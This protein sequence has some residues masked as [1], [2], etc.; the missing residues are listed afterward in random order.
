MS[1]HLRFDWVDAGPSPDVLAQYTMAALSVDAGGAVITGALDR[2]SGTYSRNVVVPLFSIAEW[3]VANWWHIWHEVGDVDKQPHPAFEARHNLAFAGDGFVLPSLRMTRATGRMR[4]EWARYSPE[5]A[6]IEFVDAGEHEVEPEELETQ[7]RNLIDAV[8]E[9]LHGRQETRA[10]AE[11]LGRAWTAV[12]DLDEE[13]LEF[14]RAAALLG[15]DPFDVP[16][17]VA[18]AL[19]VFW[20]RT[21]PSVREDALAVASEDSLARVSGWLDGAIERL[22]ATPRGGDWPVLRERLQRPDGD[23]PWALG[24]ALA[25]GARGWVGVGDGRFEFTNEGP[26]AIPREE[27]QPPS[28]RIHGLVGR[29]NACLHDGAARSDRHPVPARPRA[30][31]LPRPAAWDPPRAAQLPGDGTSGA[32]AGVRGGS[33]WRLPQRCAGRSTVAARTSNRSTISGMNSASPTG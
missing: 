13:E 7:F 21:D 24:Y 26:L 29:G 10:A 3:L 32:V 17:D 18:G 27:T 8:L 31:R 30:G 20:E 6:R 15:I 25:R 4:L 28:P 1:V 12:N 9:R 5:Y 16:D 33:F 23:E 2:Q 22:A 11:D 14:S 19:A